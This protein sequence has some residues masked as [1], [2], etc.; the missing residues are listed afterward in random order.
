M[1]PAIAMKNA[2]MGALVAIRLLTV[3]FGVGVK[4]PA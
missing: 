2:L 1:I 4:A 3:N